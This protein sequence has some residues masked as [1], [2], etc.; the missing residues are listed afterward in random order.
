MQSLQA[1][2]YIYGGVQVLSLSVESVDLQEEKTK[3]I[4]QQHVTSFPFHLTP[5]IVYL[6]VK[7]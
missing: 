1:D 5:S 2:E 3:L 6:L 7:C 4:L